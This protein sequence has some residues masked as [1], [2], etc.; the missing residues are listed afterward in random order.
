MDVSSLKNNSI[1]PKIFPPNNRPAAKAGAIKPSGDKD[2]S[3]TRKAHKAELGEYLTKSERALIDK[4]FPGNNGA[5]KV[6]HPSSDIASVKSGNHQVQIALPLDF[7][8]YLNKA[9]KELINEL[10]PSSEVNNQDSPTE[11]SSRSM[12]NNYDNKRVDSNNTGVKGRY[13]DIKA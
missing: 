9:E 13:I 10:F 4:L 5:G 2:I 7:V 12:F 8:H 3:G 1:N 11:K 6:H